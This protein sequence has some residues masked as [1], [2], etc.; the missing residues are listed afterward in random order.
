[1]KF[2]RFLLQVTG[3]VLGIVAY[4]LMQHHGREVAATT[5]MAVWMAFW[6]ITEA[7]SLYVTGLLPLIVFPMTGVLSMKEVAPE[8]MSQ[9]IFLFIGGFLLAFAMEKW[10]LH[11]RI[12]LRLILLFGSSPTRILLGFMFSS[13]FL[14]MWIMNTATVMMLLPAALA[15]LDELKS[16]NQ[17]LS[18][19]LTS[20]LL[21]G[22]AY[23]S[24]VGGTGSLIGTAPNL[25]FA[26]YMSDHHP[27]IPEIS[28]GSW[29]IY[30][31]PTSLIALGVV[32]FYLRA[33]RLR[34]VKDL[35]F[36]EGYIRSQLQKMGAMKSEEKVVGI[37]FLV[38]I[39]LWLFMKDIH[40]GN[41]HIKGWANIFPEPGFIKESTIAM[42]AA[43]I[44]FFIPSSSEKD[45]MV[46]SWAESKKIPWGLVFLFGGGFALAKAVG[47]S[48][49]SELI[50][51]NLSF[52]EG[53]P[54]M[55]TVI[56]LAL[57]MTFFTE[58]TSNTASIILILP[59]IDA[60]SQ[61]FEG[62]SPMFF[63]LPVTISAS[64]AFML[65][66]ATPPNTIVFGSERIKVPEMA[67]AGIWLNLI[68]VLLTTLFVYTIGRFVFGY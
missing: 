18:E 47:E 53:M 14:S 30:G 25:V 38:T 62:V 11:K 42:L 45:T 49:L 57:F 51:Q 59:V 64:Y 21:L 17:S 33:V 63:M 60:L 28:F 5:A 55:S 4:L 24:S 26:E 40:V 34:G 16:E 12:A 37:T 29:M 13:Y 10:K 19:K 66:V 39:F 46:L 61:H 2:P 41:V 36:S 35:K 50:A 9:I 27:E 68:G 22:L 54:V 3:P 6:W 43:G 48:G 20:P 65:P 56:I 7:T 58:L 15:V 8:Y 23:A 52:V 67:R 32:F 1:M 31:I 44:L